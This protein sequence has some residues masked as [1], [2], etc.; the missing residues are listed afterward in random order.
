MPKSL[1][2]VEAAEQYNASTSE[3]GK[4]LSSLTGTEKK[5]LL[6]PI[7]VDH[8][9]RGTFGTVAA[10]AMWT[11]NQLYGENRTASQLRENPLTGGILVAD[12]PRLNE[13]L[14]FDLRDKTVKYHETLKKLEERDMKRAREYVKENKQKLKAYDR[15][16]DAT[17]DIMEINKQIRIID[18]S[19]SDIWTPESKRQRINEL[20]E[21]KS[22]MLGN[23]TIWRREAGL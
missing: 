22:R 10:T 2:N 6:S 11:S 8:L 23:V 20:N 7:E 19:K 15:A 16:A 17:R 14:L 18:A 3:L 4:F 5:R 1:K 13:N 12:V 9:L 21:R